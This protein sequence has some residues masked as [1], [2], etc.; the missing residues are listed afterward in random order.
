[1]FQGGFVGKVKF[2]KPLFKRQQ[3][4]EFLGSDG[5]EWKLICK[6]YPEDINSWQTFDVK[7]KGQTDSGPLTKLQILFKESTDFYGRVTIYKLDV[8]GSEIK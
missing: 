1:M 7:A 2:T 8:I 6:F 5:T 4:C 3:D